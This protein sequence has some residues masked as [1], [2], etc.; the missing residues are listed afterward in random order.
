[1]SIEK[2]LDQPE[3]L[4]LLFYPRQIARNPTPPGATDIDIAVATDI[5]IGCRLFTHSTQ[6]P[7][8]I[9]YHGNGEIVADYDDIGPIYA[10]QG[11]NFIAT[12]FRGYGWSDGSPLTSALLPDSNQ[13]FLEL[14]QWLKANNY[15]GELFVMGRSLGSAPAI[16]V[17]V[18]HAD[19]ISGLIIDSGFAHT[20]PLA[21]VLGMNL[22]QHGI[23]E[24]QTFNN[25]EKI[26]AFEKPTFLLHGQVDQLI[27]VWQAETLHANCGAKAK[28]LQIIPGSDHNSLIAIGGILY[29]QTIKKFIDKTTGST[30][31]WRERRRKFKQEQQNKAEQQSK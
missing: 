24:G 6:A 10:Q 25:G 30:P 26:R 3:M 17:A 4:Q 19:S 13:I 5:K 9:F 11:L 1:M 16:D 20:L 14:Q 7:T 15:T 23:I 8:I 29:F 2:I 22:E 21:K 18:N 12:D 31:D 28:E 27:P